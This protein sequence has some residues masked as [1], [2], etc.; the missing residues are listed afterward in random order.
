MKPTRQAGITWTLL[1]FSAG[2]AVVS[3]FAASRHADPSQGL[4]IAWIAAFSVLVALWA[5]EDNRRGE[6]RP[7][8]YSW[9]L[10]IFFWPVVLAWHLV[11]TRG[12]EGFV[13]YLGFIA[14]YL[15]PTYLRMVAWVCCSGVWTT[16]PQ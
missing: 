5:R 10:M 1:A 6:G 8:E 15:A 12:L 16:I 11:K 13:L 3:A 14:I 9:L 4:A 2:Y 7:R